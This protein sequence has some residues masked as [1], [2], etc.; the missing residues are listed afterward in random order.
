[1][2][3][4]PFLNG[5]KFDRETT[6]VMGVAFELTLSALALRDRGDQVNEIVA[7]KIIEFVKQGERRSDILCE[8]ALKSLREQYLDDR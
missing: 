6:R 3:I 1:M 2:P 8:R 4:T 7:Q 5:E